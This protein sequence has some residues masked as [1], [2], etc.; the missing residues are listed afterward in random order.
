M[1]AVIS[2]RLS[3]MDFPW[4]CVCACNSNIFMVFFFQLILFTRF[5]K[6]KV[7]SREDI[8][9][10]KGRGFSAP[11]GVSILSFYSAVIAMV[12]G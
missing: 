3:P 11:H 2:S 4:E 10:E 8:R 12:L 5:K 1:R 7:E 9:N 6:K